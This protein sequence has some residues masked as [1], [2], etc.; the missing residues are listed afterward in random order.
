MQKDDAGALKLSADYVQMGGVL[1]DSLLYLRSVAKMGLGHWSDARVDIEKA[2]AMNPGS[3]EYSSL[4]ATILYR[5]RNYNDLLKLL[6]STPAANMAQSADE[7]NDL[8]FK[9]YTLLGDTN[10]ALKYYH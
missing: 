9:V 3:K 8:L 5:N 1:S 4:L 2:I 6:L 7:R 10:N